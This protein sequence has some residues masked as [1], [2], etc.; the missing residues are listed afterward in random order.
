MSIENEF[1]ILVIRQA[2]LDDEASA[3]RLAEEL[4]A[5]LT[6]GESGNAPR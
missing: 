6:Y 2:A 4:A 5:E 3:A 1:A